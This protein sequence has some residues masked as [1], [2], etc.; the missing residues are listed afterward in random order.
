MMAAQL[1]W[2]RVVAINVVY[3]L[4]LGIAARCLYALGSKGVKPW[5]MVFPKR[6]LWLITLASLVLAYAIVIYFML[7]AVP[8]LWIIAA[9]T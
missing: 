8:N 1:Y 6:K 7:V 2:D 4:G 5:R 9:I 3:F